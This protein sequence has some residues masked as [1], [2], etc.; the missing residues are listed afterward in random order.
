[1][2]VETDHSVQNTLDS[3][4]EKVDI[5]YKH[6]SLLADY[7]S[8]PR[9]Y[10]IG[11]LMTEVEVHTLGFILDQEG[12]A[13]TQLAM[14]TNRTKGAI[15]QLISKLEAKGLVKRVNEPNNKRMYRLYL[16]PEGHRACEIHR[17]YDRAGMLDMINEMLQDCTME[18]IEG[19]F[20]VMKCRN[21]ILE[22]KYEEKLR[23]K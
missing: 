13:A 10:G 3:L 23:R 14:Y 21:R 1:M 6:Q 12:I 18:E 22:K 20:K 19:F 9:D 8:T 11:Y 7:S 2:S 15:S 4:N 5:I 16:T 17:A